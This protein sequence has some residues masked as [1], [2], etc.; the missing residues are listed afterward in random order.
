MIKYRNFDIYP[1]LVVSYIMHMPRVNEA[2]T[3]PKIYP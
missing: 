1:I 3:Y 2:V